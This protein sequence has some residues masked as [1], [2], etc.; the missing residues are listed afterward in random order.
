MFHVPEKYRITY[1]P[2]GST[3]MAGNKGAFILPPKIGNRKLYIIAS[4]GIK[5]EHVSVHAF[6]GKHTRI[7]T[8]IEMCYVK[9]TFWDD[10]DVVMQLHPAKSEYIN[11]HPDVLH[12]WRPIGIAIPTPPG[13]L[14]GIKNDS[15]IKNGI[16]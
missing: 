8:W 1:G 16:H 11:N 15:E 4:D 10:E 7:P 9:D 6:V 13:I 3:F 2:Y 14:V 5:W 12:L